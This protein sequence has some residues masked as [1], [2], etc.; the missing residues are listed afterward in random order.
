MREAK[1]GTCGTCRQTVRLR[2]NGRLRLHH[3]EEPPEHHPGYT[4]IVSRRCA[5]TGERPS[6]LT[7]EVPRG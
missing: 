1:T 6:A 7:P 5:G 4:R 2:V 3:I